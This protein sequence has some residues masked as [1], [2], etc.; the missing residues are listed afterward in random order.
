MLTEANEQV[1]VFDPILFRE[2]VSKGELCF[3]RRRR[4]DV[5]PT[6]GNAVDMGINT[7]AGFLVSKC[8]HKIRGFPADS[9]EFQKLIDIVRNFTCIITK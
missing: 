9:F 2:F 4:F 1:V 5:A 6:V 3:F 8:N 7:D